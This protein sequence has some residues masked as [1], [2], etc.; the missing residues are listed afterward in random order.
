MCS[1]RDLPLLVSAEF[2]D[3][4]KLECLKHFLNDVLQFEEDE[5]WI[6]MMPVLRLQYRH[7]IHARA[8]IGFW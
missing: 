5:S 3:K 1:Y 2:T 4:V 6:G 8:L 7:S